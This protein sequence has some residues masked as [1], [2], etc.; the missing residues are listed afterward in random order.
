R[1]I[2]FPG[3]AAWAAVVES[4]EKN[5]HPAGR[6]VCHRVLGPR[7]GDT[8]ESLRPPAPVPFPSV[9]VSYAVVGSTKKNSHAAGR[10]VGHGMAHTRRRT[11]HLRPSPSGSVPFRGLT[12]EPLGAA[13]EENGHPPSRVVDHRV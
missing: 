3:L 6:V 10:V 7:R 2:P 4:T 8:H 1:S 11:H 5:G 12:A 9:P 13:S